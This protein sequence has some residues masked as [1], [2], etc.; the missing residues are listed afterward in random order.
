[1]SEPA[2]QLERKITFWQVVFYVSMATVALWL[3]L[4][5]AGIIKTPIW[6]EYGVPI[7][8]FFFSVLGM[9]K[10]I[11]GDI[12][13]VAISVT[14]LSGR[15]DTMARGLIKVEN[16]VEHLESNMFHIKNDMVLVKKKIGTDF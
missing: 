15:V 6:L 1:M 9:Y 13:K 14:K 16:K 2:F 8:G 10:E 5:L 3:I 11:L 4:K 7:G 12:H